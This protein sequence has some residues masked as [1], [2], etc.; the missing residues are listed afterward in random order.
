MRWTANLGYRITSSQLSGCMRA[1]SS[2]QADPATRLPA[3]QAYRCLRAPHR[4]TYLVA[5]SAAH[6]GQNG[7]P[8]AAR[9]M[10]TL[11]ED[12]KPQARP[13]GT[14]PHLTIE[15]KGERMS[16]MHIV[17]EIAKYLNTETSP[18]FRRRAGIAVA[19]LV[20]GK[21][22]NIQVPF[23]FKYTVDALNA[24]PSGLTP[25]SVAGLMVLGPTSL[26][27]GYG[28]ARIGASFC[29]EARNAVFASVA[30]STIRNVAVRTFAHLHNL[31][32][33]FHLSR[34]TGAVSRVI[35]RG[36]RGI[37]F[38]LSSMVFN[39]VPTA[40]EVALVAGVLA[41]KCGPAF[42]ALTGVT[43]A[44]YTAFTFAITQWR[45]QFRRQMNRAE[46]QA[47]SRAVDSLINYE[48]VKYFDA[49]E[50]EKR[51][52]D[53]CMASYQL[54]AVETQQSLSFLNFGQ[55]AIFSTSLAVAMLL[56]AQGVAAGTLTV[57]DM[58]MVNGLLLQ[59][60]MPLNFLGS[61]YR[62]TKQ[63]FIDMGAMFALLQEQTAI[64]DR[65]G[66]AIDLPEEPSGYDLTFENVSFG[67]RPDQPILQDISLTV[68]AG[69]SVALVGT[70]GSGKSTLLRLLYRFYDAQGGTVRVGGHDIK[71]LRLASLR[72]RLGA[73]PQDLV[74]FNDTVRYNIAYGKLGASESQ[75]EQAARKA[76][77]HD[78]IL[79]FPDG[80]D[81]EVGERGLKL[82][83]GE[84]QRV[85][86][87]RAFL[88]DPPVLLCDEATSALD[89]TTEK[90]ILGSLFALARGRT[91]LL[92]AHRLST[93][94][95]CD[96]IVVL[97]QGRVV[98]QGSHAQLLAAGGR[99]A[100]L[101]S[102]QQATADGAGEGVPEELEG[103][104]PLMP[105]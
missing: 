99:Y 102:R 47:S 46:S 1:W 80:Y 48:T 98:E 11:P 64:K 63:S 104:M 13:Q 73:V 74:L 15:E 96:K 61:V 16:E 78:R 54:A 20:G 88:K 9:A 5:S 71:D 22:L 85:A 44:L 82:S 12:G 50:H 90:E 68:P 30:Q 105:A 25:A 56:S 36:S 45:T 29:S 23:F 41:Y 76:A 19:L 70:S 69:T 10:A 7:L 37:N 14:Q 51:R 49:E 92:V 35:D 58:V 52:Y 39:L 59:L 28:L 81:T 2:I 33:A 8:A 87:A 17:K 6:A 94:A 40:L 66:G 26:V 24:D 65:A 97:E 95:Q 79:S 38:V 34:Q 3:L 86:L 27:L 103:A 18:E 21:L 100:E 89:S 43:I 93:A 84:K 32:L 72:R 75:V 62:E 42:A 101:W 91:T 67:Y 31:D 57:G 60:S 4:A 55:S 83:G 77:I 53:E